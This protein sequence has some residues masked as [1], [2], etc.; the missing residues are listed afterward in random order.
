MKFPFQLDLMG[1][2]SRLKRPPSAPGATP[3]SSDLSDTPIP[4]DRGIPSVNRAASLQARA[5][6]LFA[7]LL[8][9]AIGLGLLT[10]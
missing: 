6:S 8:M 10:W 9:G 3:A 7:I 2:M 1:I 4:E 5:S